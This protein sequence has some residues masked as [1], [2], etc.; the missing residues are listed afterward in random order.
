MTY[1]DAI[2]LGIV[3]GLTE[4]LP[5]SSTA[6]LILTSQVLGI[7]ADD[8]LKSFEIIIQLGAI[9]AVVTLYWRSFLQWQVLMRLAVAFV[10][11][12]LVGILL[13]PFLK[14]Y[15]LANTTV[16]LWALF[17]GGVVILVFEKWR[18]QSSITTT[19]E[20]SELSYHTCFLIGCFQS[21]AIIP[22]VSRSGAT[23]I[24]GLLLGLRRQTIVAFSFLLAVPTIAAAS[25][26]DIVKNYELFTRANV[27]LLVV[28]FVTAFIVALLSI[29]WLLHYVAKNDFT[30]FGY[31]RIGLAA[32]YAFW[33]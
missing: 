32:L 22:G 21:V 2:I 9:L 13:Y 16:V 30:V 7:T 14:Q 12:G 18:G 28:G 23:I 17:L 4:F 31:Y 1:F 19:A 24:G 26:L 15:V 10:P 5:V 3:E 6:H 11:T 8:F 27:D 29:R 25:M 33:R 20:I